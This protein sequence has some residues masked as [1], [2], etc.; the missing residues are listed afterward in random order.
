MNRKQASDLFDRRVRAWLAE[1]VDAYVACWH[2]DMRITLP[3]REDALVGVEAYRRL[4]ERS[5]AWA[6]PISFDVHALAVVVDTEVVLAEWTIRATRRADDVTVEWSGMSACE[7][8]DGRIAW[9]REYHRG[10]PTPAPPNSA[11]GQQW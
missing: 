6:K 10:P 3:G 9:W 2:D 5:F 7:V 4:V 8:R 11:G 1:D